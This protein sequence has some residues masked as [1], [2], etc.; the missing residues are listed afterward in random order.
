[1]LERIDERLYPRHAHDVRAAVDHVLVEDRGI[2]ERPDPALAQ[3]LLEI[4]LLLL[5]VDGREPE[6]QL[7]LAG[8]LARDARQPL[9]VGI[10][11]GSTRGADDRRYLCGARR[12]QYQPQVPLVGGI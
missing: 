12:K 4:I 5:A 6:G 9:E 2:G 7:L 11:A 1:V 8:D 10:A 3:L